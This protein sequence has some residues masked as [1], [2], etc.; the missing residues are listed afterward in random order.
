MKKVA[1]EGLTMIVV[2]HEISFA[3]DIVNRVLFMDGGVGV[4]QGNPAEVLFHPKEER[5]KQL[6]EM[7]FTYFGLFYIIKDNN[8]CYSIN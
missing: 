2:T 3:R 5:T 7:N 6:F 1:K 4:E 8:S